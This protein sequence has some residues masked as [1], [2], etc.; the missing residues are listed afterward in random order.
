MRFFRIF[1]SLNLFDTPFLLITK[2]IG[3]YLTSSN[4]DSVTEKQDFMQLFCLY[5]FVCASERHDNRT[6]SPFFS[7]LHS[8][9]Q[10]YSSTLLWPRIARPYD[11]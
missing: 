6:F 1:L 9:F 5:I 4:I 3:S 7:L 8:H 11:E 10:K 2:L